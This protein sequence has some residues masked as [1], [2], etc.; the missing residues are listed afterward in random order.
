MN[1]NDEVGTLDTFFL[2]MIVYLHCSA[3]NDPKND[4]EEDMEDSFNES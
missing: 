2:F 1:L 3:A 4:T